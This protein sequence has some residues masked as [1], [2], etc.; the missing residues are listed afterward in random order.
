VVGREGEAAVVLW[1]ET[2]SLSSSGVEQVAAGLGIVALGH[3]DHT[4]EPGASLSLT[5]FFSVA[6]DPLTIEA[7]RWTL[8][9]QT[10]GAVTGA[11]IEA[12][13]GDGVPGVRVHFLRTEGEGH[14][15]AGHVITRSDGGFEA[16]LPAGDWTAY[17]VAHSL[18]EH[19][20]LPVGAGRYGPFTA[21]SI[22]AQQLAALDGSRPASPLLF[23]Q[24]RETP[25]PQTISVEAGGDAS[26]QFE[27]QAATS[28]RVS[29]RD[30]QG[31]PLPG[32][33]ELRWAGAPPESLVPAE[34]REALAVP[35]G[36]RAAW[37]WTSSGE[38]D[39]P[40]L[41][42]SYT[43]HA[44]HSWRHDRATGE[45]LTLEV[46]QQGSLEL[47]LPESVPRDGW[48]SM[49]P[50]LHGA[51]SFD[52]AVP[53]E[54][55]LVVCAA[56]GVDLPI[57]TDHDRNA[58]YRPLASALGLD[59]QMRVV[60]GL[61]VTTILRG[62]FNL[63]PM[64]PEPL[65]TP[66]GGAVRWWDTPIDTQELFDRMR[67]AGG[68][69][70]LIQVNHPRSPGMFGLAS[71]DPST[72][73]PGSPRFWSDDFELM[74]LLNGGVDDLELI[75]SDWFS[76]LNLGR[77]VI[78]TGVSD[79]HY[80]YIP[81]GQGRTDVFLDTDDPMQV[82]VEDVRQAVL[83]GHVVVA[84]GT[85]LRATLDAGAGSLLPG[86]TASG[87]SGTLA[88]QVRAPPWFEPGTLRVY[89]DGEVIEELELE[90]PPVDGLWSTTAS[91]SKRALT[92]GSQWRSRAQS[93]W[94]TPGGT[95]PPTR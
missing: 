65:G 64:E 92:P 31:Q 59:G 12:G 66:N 16:R 71:Y 67:D 83:A 34:L 29:L 42:G 90:G 18:D 81:C 80:T 77:K 1:P 85:T 11:V 41:P 57:P 14:R 54:H 13:S 56:T 25:E 15:I 3:G 48:L 40:L 44:G 23:A 62:H 39:V 43:V 87:L 46:G 93:P 82:S 69:E 22:N 5:R 50:H 37:A 8:Q 75:R 2:G 7:E 33:V 60:P 73:V 49:D 27:L 91:P 24:G 38:L 76:Q 47:V 51:P 89:R 72:G 9:G 28:L 36:S 45:E 58:D 74:E 61:E 53:M 17:A 95:R 30:G 19:V 26:L 4:L 68:A 52:G 20:Q 32:V 78:P 55:R 6:P 63:F 88:V 21:A 35:G 86:D 84:A 70:A 94:G 79:S 10:L